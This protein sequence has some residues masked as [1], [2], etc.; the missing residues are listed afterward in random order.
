MIDDE[1]PNSMTTS[2]QKFLRHTEVLTCCGTPN[3]Y[4]DLGLLTQTSITVTSL[5][6]KYVHPCETRVGRVVN[7]SISLDHHASVVGVISD[8]VHYVRKTFIRF[9]IVVEYGYVHQRVGKGLDFIIPCRTQSTV[10]NEQMCL[11]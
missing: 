1:I 9:I 5:I 6:G 7:R 11:K 3:S 4:S 2:K 8:I 10:K